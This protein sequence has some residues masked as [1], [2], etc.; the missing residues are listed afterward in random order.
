M[1]TAPVTSERKSYPQ[2]NFASAYQKVS[3]QMNVSV[4][5]FFV[6]AKNF[7]KLIYLTAG[8]RIGFTWKWISYTSNLPAR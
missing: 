8:V 5:S 2:F 4:I 1:A 6:V 7:H 3:G